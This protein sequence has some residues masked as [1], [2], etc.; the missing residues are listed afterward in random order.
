MIE[1]M[2]VCSYISCLFSILLLL[3][4]VNSSHQSR[5]DS[6][7]VLVIPCP[8]TGFCSEPIPESDICDILD[9]ER[10]VMIQR[11]GSRNWSGKGEMMLEKKKQQNKEGISFVLSCTYPLL[12]RNATLPPICAFSPIVPLAICN[13]AISNDCGKSPL[14]GGALNQ[15]VEWR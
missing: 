13:F 12:Q 2:D 7:L 1:L 6:G 15:T 14:R 5:V 4:P 3:F 8:N 11:Y 9:D 10:C